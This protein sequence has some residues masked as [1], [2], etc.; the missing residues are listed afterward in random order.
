MSTP[1]PQT[2]LFLVFGGSGG[3]GKHFIKQVLSDG[4]RV[5]ALVRTP[6][7]LPP[8]PNLEIIQGSITDPLDTDALV[9]GVNNVILMLGDKNIQAT[10]K[11]N[12]ALIKQLVPSM[13]REGVKRILYLAGAFSKPYGGSLS[14]LLWVMRHTLA[15]G[16]A[17]QHSDNEA[18]MEYLA[19]EG[20]DMDWIVHRAGI[21][22]DGPSKGKL[23]R[24]INGKISVGTHVDCA[25]YNYR[26]LMDESVKKSCDL[27][28]YD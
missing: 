19:T 8:A 22:G 25:D 21:G 2:L 6:S 12:T 1:T 18:V 23:V 15:S 26:M 11:I 3:T 20:N 9:K 16:F 24:S 27:S 14:P 13:R 28:H 10:K 17:G 7:K 4:H 5:R